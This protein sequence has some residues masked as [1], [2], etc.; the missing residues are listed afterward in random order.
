ME[1]TTGK[2]AKEAIDRMHAMTTAVQVAQSSISPLS[3]AVSTEL[4]ICHT[5]TLTLTL[6]LTLNPSPYSNPNPKP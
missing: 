1:L 6:I 5:Q 3:P 2:E 4:A